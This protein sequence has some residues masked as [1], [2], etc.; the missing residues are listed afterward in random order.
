[1]NISRNIVLFLVLAVVIASSL[2]LKLLRSLSRQRIIENMRDHQF[3]AVAT[4]EYKPKTQASPLRLDRL[5]NTTFR[6]VEVIDRKRFESTI[7]LLPNGAA[8]IHDVHKSA[9]AI[10]RATWRWI[11]TQRTIQIA[12]ERLYQVRDSIRNLIIG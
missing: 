6:L 7:N 1:M 8:V 2:H 9:N 10:I 3:S 11:D 5:I 4:A 12:V